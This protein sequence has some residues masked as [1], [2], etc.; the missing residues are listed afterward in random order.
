MYDPGSPCR[1]LDP[2]GTWGTH[3]F[4]VPALKEPVYVGNNG[5]ALF[6][7]KDLSAADGDTAAAAHAFFVINGDKVFRYGN[8]FTHD[9]AP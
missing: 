3:N 4:T 9:V 7:L 8:P 5:F 1:D 2:Y 6:H